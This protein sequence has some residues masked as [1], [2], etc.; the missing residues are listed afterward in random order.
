[1]KILKISYKSLAIILLFYALVA[2]LTINTPDLPVIGESIR[3]IFY[4]VGMWFSMIA[5][6]VIS[7]GFS[8]AY[9]K[10]QKEL[11][12]IIARQSVNLAMLFGLLGILTGMIWAK[13]SWGS[14]WVN[15]PKLNGAAITMLSY[16]A[17][18]VLRGSVKDP[19]QKA[20]ISAVYNILAFAMMVVF[21][22]VLPRTAAGSI[23]PGQD[24]N[25]AL[26]PGELDA[27]MRLVFYPAI[28]GWILL[29]VWLLELTVRIEKCILS[30]TGK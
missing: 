2:G 17:Y 19:S 12:D 21:M 24:G 30:Q 22:L 15:D 28:T 27:T 20:R 23:H 11:Y 6:L 13:S 1:M 26:N 4:H 25:P 10:K 7:V 3:N 8:I 9:L 29:S 5:L 14:W 18:T 16:L